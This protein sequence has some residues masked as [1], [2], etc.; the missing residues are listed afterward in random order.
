MRCNCRQSRWRTRLASG[1]TGRNRGENVR[2][3]ARVRYGGSI[4][5]RRAIVGAL[6]LLG[7][8]TPEKFCNSTLDVGRW[9]LDVFLF[10]TRRA[11]YPG[12]FDPVTNVH[13]DVID[14]ARKLF[15]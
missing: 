1:S 2:G 12:S 7:N 11:I 5:F 8:S 10:M 6:R 4:I 14:P 13:L 9:T 3:T 15:A